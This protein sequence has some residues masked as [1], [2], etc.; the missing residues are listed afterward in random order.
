MQNNIFY[1]LVT[2]FL[3]NWLEKAKTFYA[4]AYK[5]YKFQSK[6]HSALYIP[7]YE[8]YTYRG[9]NRRYLQSSYRQFV[10]VMDDKYGK[11]N[12]DILR[13]K[14]HAIDDLLEKEYQ[15]KYSKLVKSI[16]DK[17]KVSVKSIY[18]GGYNVQCLHYR[19]TVRVVK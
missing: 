3:D 10:N 8:E 12:V 6:Y 18:A 4:E 1:K 15:R 19:T 13:Y 14:Y 17:A 11:G 7:Y 5:D 16:T 9:G 2:D